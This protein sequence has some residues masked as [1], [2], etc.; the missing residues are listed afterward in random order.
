MDAATTSHNNDLAITPTW[1]AEPETPSTARRP[2]EASYAP[3]QGGAEAA[4]AAVPRRKP[5]SF[6][7]AFLCLVIMVFVCSAD[8]TIMSVSIPVSH[9]R[10]ADLNMTQVT[11]ANSH[12]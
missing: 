3:Q 7:M 10:S 1:L 8:S 9:P 11:K 6:Y 12:R 2:K 5:L 4:E